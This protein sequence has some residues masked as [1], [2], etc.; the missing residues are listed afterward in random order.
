MKRIFWS[1]NSFL[2]ILLYLIVF[3]YS[4]Y[5]P[6]D[7][8]L[9]WH[10]KYG[11]YFWQHDSVLRDNT[12]STMMPN[13][14]WANTSWITDSISYTAYHF[15]G[16]F[17]ITLLG[18]LTVT[19]TF[20][21]FAKAFKLNL[22]E[23]TIV[24]PLVLYLEAPINNISF[25][26]Q[27]M[28]FLFTGI[29]FYLISLYKTKPKALWLAVPLF[30]VWAGVDG[31]FLLGF[32]LFA[33]WI[34]LYVFNNMRMEFLAQYQ[35]NK[36]NTVSFIEK[37]KLSMFNERK[38]IFFL[39]SIF[40]A[41][42]LA[43]LVNPFFYELHLEAISHIGSPLLKDIAEYLPFAM[44]SQEWWNEILVGVI[45]VFGMFILGFRGKFWTMLPFLGGG[46]ILFLLS[47]Q[48]RRYAWPA[49]YLL[50]PLLAMAATFLKPD[51]KKLTKITISIILI[52]QL[53][54]VVW[55]KYPFSQYMQFGWDD[56]CLL[57][58]LPCSPKSAQFLEQH[59][60]NHNLYSLYGWGGWLIWNYPKI[61]P[62]ID[63]RMHLWV[64]NGYSGFVDYYA[65]EQN[66]EDIDKT[67]Y[68]VAYMAPGKPAYDRLMQLVQLKKWKLVYKDQYAGIFIRIDR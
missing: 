8:D 29:L 20:Y 17:G 55:Q 42:V 3:I 28:V 21:F 33:F 30:L 14:H 35:N 48:V 12:F 11:E 6:S 22:W 53:V 59:Q 58:V 9:G 10:L 39:F 40:F 50:F 25:R 31:E 60:L 44:Y 26:G 49:Y 38:E 43:T 32:V 24:F 34:T 4:L 46:L 61:K 16:F 5:T 1:F 13:Y 41:S 23:Q 56:Y 66:F 51:G 68:S 15:G 36:K 64:Q 57:Q 47:L 18:T 2:P 67:N 62:T 65:I 19:M 52:L 7:P 63:G 27:Q 54:L 45:L 37:I